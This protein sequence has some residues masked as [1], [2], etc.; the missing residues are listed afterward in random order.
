MAPR[1][2]WSW[3]T[4]VAIDWSRTDDARFPWRATHKGRR[5]D[6]Y[7]GDWPSEAAYTLHVDGEPVATLE[8]WPEA[9]TKNGARAP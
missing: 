8:G 1:N 4:R 7:D 2:P 6:L 5:L 3:L 9:W